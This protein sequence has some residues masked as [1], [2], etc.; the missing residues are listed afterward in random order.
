MN[1]ITWSSHEY[2]G[3]PAKTLGLAGRCSRLFSA[4]RGTR[5]R[6]RTA[7]KALRSS[8]RLIGKREAHTRQRLT[9]LSRALAFES[10]V[11][12]SLRIVWSETLNSPA[13]PP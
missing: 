5:D 12:A 11:A 3:K 7:G 8:L 2:A 9:S 10:S 4:V 6:N 1:F 13:A